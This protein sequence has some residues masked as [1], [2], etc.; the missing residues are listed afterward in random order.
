MAERRGGP[1][2]PTESF[3]AKRTRSWDEYYERRK[4]HPPSDSLVEAMQHVSNRSLAVDL[5]AGSLRDTRF[6]L[7]KGFE[8]VIAVDQEPAVAQHASKLDNDRLEVQTTSFEKATF[9]PASVDV[10]NAH[11]S[12]PFAS[13]EVIARTIENAHAALK[14]RGVFTGQLLG[15]RDTW[16]VDDDYRTFLTEEEARALFTD[17]ELERFTEVEND[18]ER[19]H[20]LKHWHYYDIIAKKPE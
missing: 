2:Q 9:E 1:T 16:N 17:W 15:V 20:G 12:L 11:F 4:D 3:E 8:R 10:V 6:L 18:E 19:E 13:R 14:P 5:G 7:E